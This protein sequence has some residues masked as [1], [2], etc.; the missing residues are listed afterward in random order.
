MPYGRGNA[1]AQSQQQTPYGMTQGARPYDT[2]SQ[3]MRGYRP[4]D[5]GAPAQQQNWGVPS[6]AGGSMAARM[7]QAQQGYSNTEPYATRGPST[8]G[9]RETNGPANLNVA[10]GGWATTD[11]GMNRTFEQRMTPEQTARARA[12]MAQYTGGQPPRD[13][14]VV[15]GDGWATTGQEKL[16]QYAG[17]NWNNDT[18]DYV[19]EPAFIPRGGGQAWGQPPQSMGQRPAPGGYGQAMGGMG[20]ALAGAMQAMPRPQPKGPAPGGQMQMQPQAPAPMPQ[21]APQQQPMAPTENV[22]A[23]SPGGVGSYNTSYQQALQ[24][25]GRGFQQDDA[26]VQA[27]F[28]RLMKEDPFTARQ[29]ANQNPAWYQRNQMQIKDQHFGG[30]AAK[31]NAWTNTNTAGGYSNRNINNAD[32]QRRLMSTLG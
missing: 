1:Y 11:M 24:A 32:V 2:G 14:R 23:A 9:G 13:N 5:Q 21:Q 22:Q 17:G 30:D 28:D 12:E 19:N 29:Y 25:K 27:N 26:T 3:Q 18:G 7:R 20:Q 4:Y 8:V 16:P 31:R 6:D 15:G 10:D